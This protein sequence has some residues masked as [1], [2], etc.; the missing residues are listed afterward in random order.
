MRAISTALVLALSLA[1]PLAA[2]TSKPVPFSAPEEATFRELVRRDAAKPAVLKEGPAVGAQIPLD[3]MLHLVPG[4]IAAEIP[5]LRTLRYI[6]GDAGIVLVD[7]D[8]RRVVQIL[9]PR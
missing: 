2:Q 7:A 3:V 8:T 1:S 9:P 6:V 5:A 4:G